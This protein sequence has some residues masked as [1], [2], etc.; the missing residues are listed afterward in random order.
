[1]H[2]AGFNA[3][4]RTFVICLTVYAPPMEYRD[5]IASEVVKVA[6]VC[7]FFSRKNYSYIS[8]SSC[9]AASCQ[10]RQLV[11]KQSPTG[12]PCIL[13]VL[14]I[15]RCFHITFP[16][17]PLVQAV[18]WPVFAYASDTAEP[19]ETPTK[20]KQRDTIRTLHRTLLLFA[21]R[22]RYFFFERLRR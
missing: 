16:S 14:S 11:R 20:G 9:H 3:A 4:L 6:F 12:F 5:S 7:Y 10:L 19:M 13:P 22:C 18:L 15:S 1:M 17:I 2:Y 21:A 8:V